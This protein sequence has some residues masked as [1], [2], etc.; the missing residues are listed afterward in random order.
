MTSH[1]ITIIVRQYPNYVYLHV[2]PL[3]GKSPSGHLLRI[4]ARELWRGGN[5]NL[6]A[7]VWFVMF[8]NNCDVCTIKFAVPLYMAFSRK[9]C[10]GRRYANQNVIEYLIYSLR[11][12]FHY[13]FVNQYKKWRT[14]KIIVPKAS[15]QDWSPINPI[16]GAQ[17]R[18]CLLSCSL[19]VHIL[20][21]SVYRHTWRRTEIQLQNY[22]NHLKSTHAND[23]TNFARKTNMHIFKMGNENRNS[24]IQFGL[25]SKPPE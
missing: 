23:W 10:K 4:Y 20:Y 9:F 15:S 5:V 2:H 14:V 7:L 1:K 3:A 19:I 8:A 18:I 24:L 6:T 25:E 22:S 17:T 12:F 21:I 11:I 13:H 16:S